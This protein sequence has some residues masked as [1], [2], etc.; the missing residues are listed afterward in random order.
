MA[1]GDGFSTDERA[2]VARAVRDAERACGFVFSVYV[3]AADGEAGPYARRLHG[4][5]KDPAN[6]VLVLVD[7]AARLLEIVT[8]SEV[9]RV[10]PDASLGL[11]A[12]AMESAFAV[13]DIAGGITRGLHLLAGAARQPETLHF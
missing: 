3:G 5:L 6:S 2:E 13:G 4:G 8:G 11:A 9:R 10:V 12:A 1:R 7:P